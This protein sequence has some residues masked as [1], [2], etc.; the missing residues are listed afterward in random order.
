[1]NVIKHTSTNKYI[2]NVV[3]SIGVSLVIEAYLLDRTHDELNNTQRMDGQ[4]PV[5]P[6]FCIKET[7]AMRTSF[8]DKN[9]MNF[10]TEY[11]L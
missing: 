4:S 6:K 8:K 11:S 1:M 5:C 2:Y 3:F 10:A 7:N 9:T